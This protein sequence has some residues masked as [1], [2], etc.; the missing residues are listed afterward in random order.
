[1]ED[2]YERLGK[3]IDRLDSL[4][5]AL[6]MPLP[7]EMHVEGLKKPLPEIVAELKES[8]VEITGDNPWQ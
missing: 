1:M 5:H 3:L 2:K 6:K 8:F 4:A 7:A